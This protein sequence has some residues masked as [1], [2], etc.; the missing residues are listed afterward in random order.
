[1]EKEM[2]DVALETL[3]RIANGETE[4]PIG[5]AVS[6][7]IRINSMKKQSE[8][9]TN[10]KQSEETVTIKKSEYQELKD[11][12]LWLTALEN[13]GVDNWEGYD[14]AYDTLEELKGNQN[15]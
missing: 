3:Q 1:M 14:F 12:D 2:L 6:A 4:H 7:I 13:C 11:R 10:I 5:A 9:A 8:E 15:G